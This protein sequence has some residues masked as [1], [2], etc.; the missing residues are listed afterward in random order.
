M[1]FVPLRKLKALPPQQA[2]ET[3]SCS[4]LQQSK[5]LNLL[6]DSYPSPA[7]DEAMASS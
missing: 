3:E 7:F 2:V 6:N 5:V 4:G 1:D